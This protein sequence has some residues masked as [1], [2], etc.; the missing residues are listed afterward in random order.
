MTPTGEITM[1]SEAKKFRCL[2]RLSPKPLYQ[3]ARPILIPAHRSHPDLARV[4]FVI[5]LR[6]LSVIQN[7]GSSPVTWKFQGSVV[8]SGMA[9][10]GTR[11][12]EAV[13]C[14]GLPRQQ[15]DPRNGRA[16]LP[17]IAHNSVSRPQNLGRPACISARRRAPVHP[18]RDNR[19]PSLLHSYSKPLRSALQ[20]CY[21][22]PLK[23]FLLSEKSWR[24]ERA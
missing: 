3:W 21:C 22:V 8:G 15:Q 6:R 2:D 9:T 23:W 24:R 16:I 5:G 10:F 12:A 13:V 14:S 11:R 1:A 18:R 7:C 17:S 20:S 19:P 4:S